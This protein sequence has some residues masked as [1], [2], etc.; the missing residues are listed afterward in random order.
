MQDNSHI[1]ADHHLKAVPFTRIGGM[2]IAVIDRAGSAAMMLREASAR[3]RSGQL[4]ALLTSA[5]G[6]VLSEY[7][8]KPA[9][10]AQFDRFDMVHAD[11][12]PLVWAS[13]FAG[14]HQLPER[15]ATTDLVHDVA[16]LAVKSG[17]SFYLLGADQASLT[18]ALANL[19]RAY[20]GLNICGARNGYFNTEDEQDV[21]DDINA[22]APD[23]LWVAMGVPREQDFCLRNRHRLTNVGLIKTSGGLFDFLSNRRSRAPQWM[24]TLSLEWFYR[25]MLEPRRLFWRY[26]TTNIHALFLLLTRT[27]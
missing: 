20:P 14:S 21:I 27:G 26:F 17:A 9:L 8:A 16:R 23:I 1:P 11:G 15:V 10:R 18:A 2:K 5:N 25:M 19:R 3:K 13:H 4:P 24:Q 6:Q 22:A 12:M 7:A